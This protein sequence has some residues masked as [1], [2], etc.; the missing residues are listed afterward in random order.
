MILQSVRNF[1]W[2]ILDYSCKV[3]NAQ[4]PN[5]GQW[6]GEGESSVDSCTFLQVCL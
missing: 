1:Y 6:N 3:G 2:V 4:C 5:V